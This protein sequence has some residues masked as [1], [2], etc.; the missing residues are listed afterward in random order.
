MGASLALGAVWTGEPSDELGKAVGT[1]TAFALAS[2]QVSALAARRQPRDPT[3]VHRLFALSFA[4]E[5][6]ARLGVER[7]CDSQ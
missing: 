6:S 5:A 7:A 3:S 1:V 4:V 2:T